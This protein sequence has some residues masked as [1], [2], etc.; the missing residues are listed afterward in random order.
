VSCAN[1]TDALALALMAWKKKPGDAVR[2]P[3]TQV[4]VI[5]TVLAFNG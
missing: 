4:R 5:D 1:G 2:E 3:G